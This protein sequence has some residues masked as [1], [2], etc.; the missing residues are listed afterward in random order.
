MIPSRDLLRCSRSLI[1]YQRLNLINSR[2][3]SMKNTSSSGNDQLP[4]EPTNCCMSGCANCVWIEY[5]RELTRI[6][7][8]GGEK[9]RKLIT[10]RI[11]D[12]NIRTFLE[13]ELKNLDTIEDKE[14]N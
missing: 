12:P 6:Y 7:R 5:A 14:Q 9:A 11:T 4:D 13:M 1:K 3:C 10:S 8:D 2:Q